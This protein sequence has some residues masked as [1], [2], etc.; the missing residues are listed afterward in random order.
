MKPQHQF[1]VIVPLGVIVG[2][3]VIAPLLATHNPIVAESGTELAP[4]ST[5]HWLGTDRLGRD[6]WSRLVI[7]GRRT[8]INGLLATTIS[9]VGGL[10]LAAIGIV[11]LLRPVVDLAANALLAF[12]PLLAAL[13]LRAALPSTTLTLAIAVGL[14]TM[15]SYGRVAIDAAT[16]ARKQPYIEGA[17]SIGASQWRIFSR[18]LLPTAAPTLCAFAATIFAWSILYGASLSFLGLGDDLSAPEWGLM[19]AQGRGTLVQAPQLVFFPSAMIMLCIWLAF[20]LAD[21]MAGHLK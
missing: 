17:H 4:P 3:M 1:W 20:R 16:L 14:A 5:D 19:I 9:V 10:L 7:G 8:L 6:E 18:Y 13:L 21:A 12:P 11:P 15:G 2:L